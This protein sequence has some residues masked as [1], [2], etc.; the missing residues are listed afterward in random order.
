MLTMKSLMSAQQ[1]CAD[2]VEELY[3]GVRWLA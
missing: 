2:L 1:E 3:A